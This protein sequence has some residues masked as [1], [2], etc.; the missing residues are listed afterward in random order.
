MTDEGLQL[1]EGLVDAG[2]RLVGRGYD[3]DETNVVK[4]LEQIEPPERVPDPG[5]AGLGSRNE[6]SCYD[7]SVSY[8]NIDALRT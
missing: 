8:E 4:I 5:C 1:Q 2:W 6:E 7:H 3:P